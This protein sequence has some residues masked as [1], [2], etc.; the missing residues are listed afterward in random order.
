MNVDKFKVLSQSVFGKIFICPSCNKIH[1]EFKNL[2]FSFTNTEYESFA[3]YFINFDVQYWMEHSIHYKNNGK[4]LIPVGH[5]NIATLFTPSEIDELKSL[6]LA[7][8][9]KKPVS[10]YLDLGNGIQVCQN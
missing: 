3:N 1:V 4:I 2:Y 7:A 5:K 10:Q 9:P 6:F 8:S